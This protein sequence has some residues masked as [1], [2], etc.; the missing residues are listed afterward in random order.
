MFCNENRFPLRCRTGSKAMRM[1]VWVWYINE[2]PDC[3]ST[4]V[5]FFYWIYTVYVI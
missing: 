1:F 4:D 2:T 5:T 3:Q